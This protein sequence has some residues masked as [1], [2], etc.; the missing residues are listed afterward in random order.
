MSGGLNCG[1]DILTGVGVELEFELS[2]SALVLELKLSWGVEE[3]ELELE[4]S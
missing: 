2:W 3:V 1:V 4:W